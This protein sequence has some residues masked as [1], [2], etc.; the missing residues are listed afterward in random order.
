MRTAA[1]ERQLHCRRMHCFADA[2]GPSDTRRRHKMP[3]NG[4]SVR[5]NTTLRIAV[6]D[7]ISPESVTTPL[8]ATLELNSTS[9]LSAVREA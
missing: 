4:S 2:A 8:R 1:K 6:S 3:Q 9:W 7:D 5:P